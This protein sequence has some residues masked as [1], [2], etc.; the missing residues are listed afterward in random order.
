M[1]NTGKVMM[2]AA[3]AF[4]MVLAGC[5][6]KQDTKT[7][8]V[9][10][11]DHKDTVKAF[12]EGKALVEA[13]T[14]ADYELGSLDESADEVSFF[15]NDKY[16]T[17]KV[18]AEKGDAAAEYMEMQAEYPNENFMPENVYEADNRELSTFLNQ[19]NTIYNVAAYDKEADVVYSIENIPE[20]DL[21]NVLSVFAQ[22]GFTVE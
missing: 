21:E 6:A 15:A 12:D 11:S 18:E 3:M 1:K 14:N 7:E 8:K 22:L 16:G 10:E 17:L 9:V 13:F 20:A 5:S 4:S 2:A 19:M